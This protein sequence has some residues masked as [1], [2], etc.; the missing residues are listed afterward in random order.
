[1]INYGRAMKHQNEA[2][3][4]RTRQAEA[5]LAADLARFYAEAQAGLN[6]DLYG[7]DHITIDGEFIEIP[8]HKRLT[9]G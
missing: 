4:A 3:D 8:D 6:K 2:L 7:D 1:M 5:Q 9:H